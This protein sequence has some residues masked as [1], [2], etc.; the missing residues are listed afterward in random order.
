MPDIFKKVSWYNLTQEYRE[1]M[2]K[3]LS[4]IVTLV[5]S[6]LYCA[7]SMAQIEILDKNA[8]PMQI[9]VASNYESNF[10]TTLVDDIAAYGVVIAPEGR[11]ITT[12]EQFWWVFD[13]SANIEMYELIDN[14]SQPVIDDSFNTLTGRV[15]LRTFIKNKWFVDTYIQRVEQTQN[16]NDGISR[17]QVGVTSADKLSQNNA[18]ISLVYGS[19]ISERFVSI[20]ALVRDDQY[21]DINTYSSLFNVTQQSLEVD[22][23]FRQSSSSRFLLKTSIKQDDYNDTARQDSKLIDVLLGI[24]WS[25]SG[26]SKLEALVGK[27]QRNF[28]D[29]SSNTGVSWLVDYVYRPRED[30]SFSLKSTRFSDVTIS[31]LT[32]DT[33]TQDIHLGLKY[34]YSQRWSWGVNVGSSQTDFKRDKDISVLDD[35]FADLELGMQL[36]KHSIILLKVGYQQV[37]SENDSL[38]YEQNKVRLAWQYTF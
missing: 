35:S 25:F 6:L 15:L 7:I 24:E 20:K 31:V 13:Y 34:K 14:T 28:E 12:L 21:E 8:S 22:L 33:V 5:S 23:A 2:N 17:L 36:K 9:T 30:I 29:G 4:T 37:E 27:Y 10:N 1:S 32:T 18:G 11:L 16:F 38:A 26:K 3:I 19:D